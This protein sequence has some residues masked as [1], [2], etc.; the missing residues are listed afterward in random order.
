MRGPTPA[1]MGFAEV[2]VDSPTAPGRTFSYSIPDGLRVGPW[3]PCPRPIRKTDSRRTRHVAR[4]GP[5]GHRNATYPEHH[6]RRACPGGGPAAARTVDQRVLHQFAV[7]S[8]RADA[9]SRPAS[10]PADAP[11]RWGHRIP[12]FRRDCLRCRPGSSTTYDATAVS[13]SSALSGLWERAPAHRPLDWSK[14]ASWNG[15]KAGAPPEP[16]PSS[17]NTQGCLQAVSRP[18]GTGHRRPP[19][20]LSRLRFSRSS[21]KAQSLCVSA[22]PGDS[23]VQAR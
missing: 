21:P 4:R 5:A 18:P 9:A 14:G 15:R 1:T 12:R 10:P 3:P 23:T 6:G 11:L 19:G 2:A 17:L 22:T 16:A 20:R 7:R 13:T 8:G